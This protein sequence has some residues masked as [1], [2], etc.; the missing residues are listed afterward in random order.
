M[1]ENAFLV[2]PKEHSRVPYG[3]CPYR[4]SHS[5]SIG[6]T[7][8]ARWIAAH[9]VSV[10]YNIQQHMLAQYTGHSVQPEIQDKKPQFPYTL[11]QECGFLYLISGCR[12]ISHLLGCI[13]AYAMSVQ[14]TS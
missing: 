11:Y 7:R 4:T 14:R 8:T 10:P 2:V 3:V 6:N 1:Q 9:A 13:A 5:S 12:E